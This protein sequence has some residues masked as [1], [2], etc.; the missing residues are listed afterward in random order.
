[1][2]LADF[3]FFHV[4]CR[5]MEDQQSQP[6]LDGKSYDE[7]S[8]L[9]FSTLIQATRLSNT[10]PNE[11]DYAYYT[12]F[13]TFPPRMKKLGQTLLHR[14]HQIMAHTTDSSA[15]I[16]NIDPQVDDLNGRFTDVVESLDAL[17]EQVVSF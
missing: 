4:L 2:V 7:Y 8:K 3:I 12:A 16:T 1:M 10:L 13:P 17:L 9:L 6:F 11:D 5:G 14:C 15:N